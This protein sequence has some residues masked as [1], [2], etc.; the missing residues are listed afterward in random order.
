MRSR[1]SIAAATTAVLSVVGTIV[2]L[3][4]VSWHR[5]AQH[6]VDFSRDI[7]P[8]LNQSCVSC[9][10]GVRQKNEVSFIYREEAL[11]KGKSGRRTIVSGH[12]E[13]SELMARITG[14]PGG[15]V[16]GTHCGNLKLPTRV[17]Q[18][19]VAASICA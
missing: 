1:R 8:I 14:V 16:V 2:A 11:G 9:H 19:P 3:P 5:S 17:C 12:P 13:T 7:R 18:L 10:G 6:R 4:Y 15:G